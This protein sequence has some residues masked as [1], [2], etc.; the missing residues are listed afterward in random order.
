MEGH[1]QLAKLSLLLSTP[2]NKSESS[3]EPT[4]LNLNLNVN[5]ISVLIRGSQ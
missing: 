5:L 3:L 4:K 2:D 1:T